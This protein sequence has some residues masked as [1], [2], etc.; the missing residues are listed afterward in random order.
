MVSLEGLDALVD[1]GA[2]T[3]NHVTT[4]EIFNNPENKGEQVVAITF[5]KG[6]EMAYA[7]EAVAG[8]GNSTV[9][10]LEQNIAASPEINIDVLAKQKNTTEVVDTADIHLE[11]RIIDTNKVKGEVEV[12]GTPT[13]FTEMAQNIAAMAQEQQAEPFYSPEVQQQIIDQIATQQPTTAATSYQPTISQ[14]EVK[15]FITDNANV[16]FYDDAKSP[17]VRV[18]FNEKTV[19][20]NRL[21]EQLQALANEKTPDGRSLLGEQGQKLVDD[22]LKEIVTKYPEFA[23]PQQENAVIIQ[24]QPELQAA[25]SADERGHEGRRKPEMLGAAQTNV[26]TQSVQMEQPLVQVAPAQI[27]M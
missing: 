10:Q 11:H 9:Q 3:G 12:S 23:L 24:P 13:A 6:L 17:I 1:I 22:A 4:V 20:F 27:G 8:A 26:A 5:E 2:K 7:Q 14:L 18:E 25:A 19:D 15:E 21:K 16:I